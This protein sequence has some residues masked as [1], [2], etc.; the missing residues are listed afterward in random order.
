M[1]L[2]GEAWQLFVTATLT[3][4]GM[5]A[6]FV[7][8]GQLRSTSIDGSEVWVPPAPACG[9]KSLA[10]WDVAPCQSFVASPHD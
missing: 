3:V 8:E 5:L 6:L 1:N 9:R 4:N 10:L 7:Q 2:G